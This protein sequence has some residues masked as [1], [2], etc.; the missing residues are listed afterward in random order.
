MISEK[1]LDQQYNL[2]IKQIK[3]REDHLAKEHSKWEKQ[4][5]SFMDY[6]NAT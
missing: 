5:K 2:R 1:K 6:T 4:F 3:E